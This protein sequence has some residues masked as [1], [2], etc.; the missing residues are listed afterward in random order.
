M[1]AQIRVQVNAVIVSLAVVDGIQFVGLL[2]L[3]AVAMS[4]ILRA[5]QVC[6]AACVCE[7]SVFV[8]IGLRWGGDFSSN[9]L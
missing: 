1:A 6:R 7:G 3:A 9:R 8:R 4:P 5:K 2:A